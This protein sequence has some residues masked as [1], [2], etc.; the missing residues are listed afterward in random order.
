MSE[1][2]ATK[3]LIR[4]NKSFVSMSS[5]TERAEW[6]VWTFENRRSESARSRY[7]FVTY[8]KFPKSRLWV[9]DLVKDVAKTAKFRYDLKVDEFYLLMFRAPAQSYGSGEIRAWF[10]VR[11]KDNNGKYNVEIRQAQFAGEDA[12]WANYEWHYG[13][14]PF[15]FQKP[16]ALAPKSPDPASKGSMFSGSGVAHRQYSKTARLW[17]THEAT[18]HYPKTATKYYSKLPTRRAGLPS[19]LPSF[20]S[21]SRSRKIGPRKV[22]RDQPAF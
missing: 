20:S 10:K 1:I 8:S 17:Y 14:D 13:L 19:V 2:R 21:A 9:N 3:I 7:Q 16:P 18:P 12:K 4:V 15:R 5:A 6:V 11:V 22:Y